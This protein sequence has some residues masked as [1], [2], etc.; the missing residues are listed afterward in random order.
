MSVTLQPDHRISE[1]AMGISAESFRKRAGDAA[2]ARLTG[3]CQG[4]TGP[5]PPSS[6]R[7]SRLHGP[8]SD[9]LAGTD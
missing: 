5:G 8:F 4:R 2:P 3:C 6:A 1:P 9:R 7:V